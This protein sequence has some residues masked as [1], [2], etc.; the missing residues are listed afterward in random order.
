M[1]TFLKL[2]YVCKQVELA[3]N[4]SVWPPSQLPTHTVGF[5]AKT[6]KCPLCA[7]HREY[8]L[9][10]AVGGV[11]AHTVPSWPPFQGGTQLC[12]NVSGAGELTA[13]GGPPCPCAQLQAQ[14]SYFS[15]RLRGSALVV[16][17]PLFGCRETRPSTSC[18]GTQQHTRWG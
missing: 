7:R 6:F 11:P 16:E 8:E 12:L 5:S 14:G 9:H 17:F 4:N 15:L 2:T 13:F 18:A 3:W 10:R 1:P